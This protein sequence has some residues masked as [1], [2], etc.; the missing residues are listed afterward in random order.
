MCENHDYCYVQ[1]PNNENKILEYKHSQKSKRA[2]FVIY[3]DLEC[4]LQRPMMKIM[5]KIN[6]QSKLIIIFLVNIQC[7][8]SAHLII[9]KIN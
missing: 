5:I 1:M 2:S 3:S 4:L 8:L 7:T 9:L 6:Q